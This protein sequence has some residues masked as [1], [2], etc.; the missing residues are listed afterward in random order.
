[1]EELIPK[2]EF[3]GIQKQEQFPVRQRKQ[4]I[5]KEEEQTPG[6]WIQQEEQFPPIRKQ[7]EIVGIQKEERFVG[8]QKW[9][10]FPVSQRKVVE[11]EIPAI[12]K[13]EEEIPEI[14]KAEKEQKNLLS[15]WRRKNCCQWKN[16]IRWKRI[17]G[18]GSLRVLFEKN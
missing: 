7:E 17:F 18:L 2:E 4:E 6:F 1:M 10:Q 16:L 3:W 14:Q 15:R 8:I 9:E 11:Q 5:R 12:W 13:Q